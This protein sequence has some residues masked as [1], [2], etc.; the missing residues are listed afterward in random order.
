MLYRLYWWKQNE[1]LEKESDETQVGNAAVDS[2]QASQ[3][4]GIIQ[5]QQMR[6]PRKRARIKTSSGRGRELGHEESTRQS[7]EVVRKNPKRRRGGTL[8]YSW[9]ND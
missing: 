6:S 5:R 4:E 9:E 8:W 7:V 3:K 1:D 2:R